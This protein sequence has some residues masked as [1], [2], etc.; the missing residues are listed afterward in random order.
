MSTVIVCLD[1]ASNKLVRGFDA[2]FSCKQPGWVW[3]PSSDSLTALRT[4]QAMRRGDVTQ[5]ERRQVW[6]ARQDQITETV[7]LWDLPQSIYNLAFLSAEEDLE[8]ET[9]G[10]RALENKAELDALLNSMADAATICVAINGTALRMESTEAAQHTA[11]LLRA[12]FRFTAAL[13]CGDAVP[14]IVYGEERPSATE[15]EWLK[16]NLPA[17]S[18]LDTLPKVFFADSGETEAVVKLALTAHPAV[19]TI[20]ER[21]RKAR[22][23]FCEALEACETWTSSSDVTLKPETLR[24]ALNAYINEIE[25]LH[26]PLC[27]SLLDDGQPLPD[28]N[29]LNADLDTLEAFIESAPAQLIGKDFSAWLATTPKLN[30]LAG[31]HLAESAQKRFTDARK[32]RMNERI[33]TIILTFIAGASVLLFILVLESTQN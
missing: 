21:A 19:L 1:G 26:W 30:T 5:H 12:I 32:K 33:S 8:P 15:E 22:Q 13:P 31:K 16:V 28:L 18:S 20:Y 23:A 3:D 29:A 7:T 2:V 24:G 6:E 10:R 14:L 27:P 17:L 11:W 9:F 25:Q 4:A